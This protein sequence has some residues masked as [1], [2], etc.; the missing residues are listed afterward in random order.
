MTSAE[1]GPKQPALTEEDGLH[2]LCF[3]LDSLSDVS[4]CAAATTQI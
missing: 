4:F 3:T 2:Q 1:D